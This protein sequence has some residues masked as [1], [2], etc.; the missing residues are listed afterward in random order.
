MH[1][2]NVPMLQQDQKMIRSM[3]K[4]AEFHDVTTVKHIYALI[5]IFNPW[6]DALYCGM[7]DITFKRSILVQVKTKTLSI[8]EISPGQSME[9]MYFNKTCR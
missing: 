7:K 4:M 5:K 9:I 3:R 8:N 2:F 6:S 1:K